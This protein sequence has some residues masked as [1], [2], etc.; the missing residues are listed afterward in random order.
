MSKFYKCI[1]NFLGAFFIA[2]FCFLIFNNTSINVKAVD[3]NT[4]IANT[5][6]IDDGYN[7]W[8]PGGTSVSNSR[9][10][11][12]ISG[13][14]SLD[15]TFGSART[16]T[17]AVSNQVDPTATTDVVSMPNT[18]HVGAGFNYYSKI[19]VFINNNG[20]YYSIVHQGQNSY[21]GGTNAAPQ[22]ASD[23]SMDFGLT[24]GQANQFFG[25]FSI[26]EKMEYKTILY[27]T[28][29]NHRNVI[30]LAGYLSSGSGSGSY[31]EVVLRPSITGAPIV[32]RELYIYNPT[33]SQKQFQTYFGEDTALTSDSTIFDSTGSLDP[34]ANGDNVPLYAI[35]G[36]QGLYIN[37]GKSTGSSNSKLFVTNNVADGFKDFMGIAFS[38]PY[39]MAVKGKSLNG[40]SV[41][42]D[43]TSP[44]LTVGK[45]DTG[46]TNRPAGSPLLW[47]TTASGGLFPVVDR[48]GNQ[49]SAYTLRWNSTNLDPNKTAH[50]ASTIGATI[51][52]YAVPIVTKTYTNPNQTNGLNHVGDT[53]HFKLKVDNQGLNSNWSFNKL[54]DDLPAGLQLDPNSVK[55]SSTYFAGTT[56]SGE[57]QKDVMKDG[58]YGSFINNSTSQLNVTPN[59]ILK[60]K[61]TYTVTFDATVTL[62]ALSNL[63][64]G[65]LT[66]AATFTGNNKT[67]AGT[68]LDTNRDYTDSVKI[69]IAPS[70]YVPKFTKTLRNSTTNSTGTFSTA[71]TG[72]KG[73]T[74]DYKV[75]LSNTGTDSLK[76]ANFSD[77][78]PDGLELKDGTVEVTSNGVTQK[79]DGLS[80]ALGPSSS[81]VTIDFQ[82]TVTS[83]KALTASN[84]AVLNDIKTNSGLSYNNYESNAAVLTIDETAPTMSLD[85]VPSMIDFGSINSDG[86][87]R[88][89]PN[90]RTNG[91]LIFTHTSDTPFQITVGYNNDGSTPISTKDSDGNIVNKLVQNNDDA[92]YYNQNNNVGPAN[93]Q[94][95]S[96]SGI[97]IKSAG[98]SGSYTGK[99]LTDYVGLDKWKLL[100]PSNTKAGQYKGT[101]TWSIFDTPQS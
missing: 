16:Q 22:K 35:G 39:S 65:A 55:F 76:S 7:N 66:N 27:T 46:D 89:L 54:V 90:V 21:I 24:A 32:Q 69:P 95:L 40:G 17:G 93:W 31:A 52:P 60:D 11:I 12:P 79:K 48:N 28:D 86:S 43:I 99:D 82:A 44:S 15:Y 92:L 4:V 38:S 13:G 100:I 63:S 88:M 49:N 78:L 98:F 10:S 61:G 81:T 37:S 26:T 68:N 18:A 42:G 85:E 5:N 97:P 19:N 80:F 96:A 2:L 14:I 62:D 59:A 74:I 57:D 101:I 25:S 56:G 50:F 47:G 70:T 29:S 91:R 67:S 53:L 64:N 45:N 23:S 41:T 9:G 6:K 36:G 3:Q 58:P 30:K 77:T 83:V 34:G 33:G 51:S 75:Q 87:Q 72:K 20:K 8:M 84:V 71:A 94:P 73:D 1:P